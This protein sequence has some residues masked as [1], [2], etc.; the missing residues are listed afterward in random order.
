MG[1]KKVN[2]VKAVVRRAC[3]NFR[4]EF[5]GMFTVQMPKTYFKRF[6]QNGPLFFHIL[7]SVDFYRC[8]GPPQPSMVIPWHRSVFLVLIINAMGKGH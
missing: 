2:K 8:L 5:G 6:P 3:W 1:L 7:S 4:D